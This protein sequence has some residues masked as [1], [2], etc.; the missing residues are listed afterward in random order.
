MI[1]VVVIVV[2]TEIVIVI[3]IA[4][5]IVIVIVIDGASRPAPL[6]ST[7]WTELAEGRSY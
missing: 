1:R 6:L 2:V 7:A 3:V 5:V 4:I